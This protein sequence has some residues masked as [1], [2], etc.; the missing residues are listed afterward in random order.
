MVVF[1]LRKA[2]KA[3]RVPTSPRT[4]SSSTGFL[5]GGKGLL[6]AQYT[7]TDKRV[8][9]FKEL[10]YYSLKGIFTQLTKR[11]HERKH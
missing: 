3:K 5:G 11:S 2:V 6:L 9:N 1:L 8:L 10:Q 7:D 4:S